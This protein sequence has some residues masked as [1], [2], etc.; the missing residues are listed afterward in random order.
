M[1]VLDTSVND[2][3]RLPRASIP[4]GVHGVGLNDADSA[5]ECRWVGS[6]DFDAPHRRGAG[7]GIKS[8]LINSG[9]H[10]TTGGEGSENVAVG[11]GE[12]L[13]N[14]VL[15]RGNC[16]TLINIILPRACRAVSRA[17]GGEGNDDSGIR[18]HLMRASVIA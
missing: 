5:V 17:L 2:D 18:K 9:A 12:C 11:G 4:I 8:V 16:D 6:I 7:K 14:N 15:I 1:V 10:Q 13:P 3:D